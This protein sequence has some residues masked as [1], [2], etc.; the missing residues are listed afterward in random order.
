[1]P[2][3]A[4]AARDEL[5]EVR[6]RAVFALGEIGGLAETAQKALFGVLQDPDPQVRVA[7]VEALGKRDDLG[8]SGVRALLGAVA[9]TNSDVKAQV[10]CSLVQR[11][12][13]AAEV[14][15]GLCRLLHDDNPEVQVSA[16]KALGKLGP[17]AQT[18][19]PH[20]M[21]A[22]QTGD[23]A[24]REQ[25]MRAVVLIQPREASRV[26]GVG[27]KDAQEEV[28]KLASAGLMKVND[29]APEVVPELVEA[30]RDPNIQVRSNAAHA[31][32]R[33]EPVPD[34]AIPLL[35]ECTADPDDGL[36]MNAVLALKAAS[37]EAVNTV[38]HRL[39]DDPNVRIRLVAAGYLLLAN[40]AD[41]RGAAVLA[42]A[43]TQP[44]TRIRKTAVELVA[45]L[46]PKGGVYL[47]VIKQRMEVEEE[48]EIRALIVQVVENLTVTEVPAAVE[49]S[50]GEPVSADVVPPVVG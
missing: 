14:I 24:V 25:A 47:D 45:S 46:G 18:A 49:V 38:V 43:L 7:A 22:V 3:L 34:Q 29:I 16:A 26:F 20:L 12:G 1:V 36:R 8:E 2:A 30:L 41:P 28:R 39:I 6:G 35:V 10:T 32:S 17:D 13:A 44:A 19:G 23:A 48:P 5:G 27:L 21:H 33:L 40:P 4:E 42:E 37:P 15:E 50:A 31:L 9:D 11:V